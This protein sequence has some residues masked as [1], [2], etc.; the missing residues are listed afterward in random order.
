MPLRIDYGDL[1]FLVFVLAIGILALVRGLQ[2]RW[3]T[4]PVFVVSY[5]GWSSPALAMPYGAVYMFTLAIGTFRDDLPTWLFEVVGFVMMLSLLILLLG[6]FVWFP[7][8]LLPGWY[9]RARKAGVPRHDP[10]AMARFKRLSRAEQRW[11]VWADLFDGLEGEVCVGVRESLSVPRSPVG[12]AAVGLVVGLGVGSS[13]PVEVE[14]KSLGVADAGERF[15][16]GGK[17]LWKKVFG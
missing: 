2:I 16:T 7:W 12:G 6:F 3:A 11:A 15:W 10:Y 4:V 17:D 8:F 5:R 9:R 14:G 13:I 1:V